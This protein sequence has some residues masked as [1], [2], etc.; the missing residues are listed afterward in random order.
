MRPS[1]DAP[2]VRHRTSTPI[3]DALYAEYRRAFKALPG[4]RSGEEDYEFTPFDSL[5]STVDWDRI[6][7]WEP[8]GSWEATGRRRRR[9]NPPPALPPGN[10]DDRRHGL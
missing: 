2:V 10:R 8:T 1:Y 9:G 7:S 4:D 3:Y 5:P 6:S